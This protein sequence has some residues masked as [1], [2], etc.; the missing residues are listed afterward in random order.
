MKDEK[1]DKDLKEKYKNIESNIQSEIIKDRNNFLE[2]EL[3]IY[4]KVPVDIIKSK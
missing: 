3:E 1:K 2:K 4:K